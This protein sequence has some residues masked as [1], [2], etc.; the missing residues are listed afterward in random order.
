MSSNY[1]NLLRGELSFKE[2]R[3]RENDDGKNN[4]ESL[5]LGFLRDAV[6]SDSSKNLKRR[7]SIAGRG[8][9][10]FNRRSKKIPQLLTTK[11]LLERRRRQNQQR[12][13]TTPYSTK[14]SKIRGL[15]FSEASPNA[16]PHKHAK[17][18]T[19]PPMVYIK[20]RR[21]PKTSGEPSLLS[22]VQTSSLKRDPGLTIDTSSSTL[23]GSSF[24]H[25]NANSRRP[26]TSPMV[27]ISKSDAAMDEILNDFNRLPWGRRNIAVGKPIKRR[28]YR[29]STHR[30]SPQ[31][32]QFPA[33]DQLKERNVLPDRRER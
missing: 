26:S 22:M 11:D 1:A 33:I 14:R 10:N 21:R 15:R 30:I 25:N 3:M 17:L 12:P 27:G 29:D 24:L 31:H 13:S 18:D 16:A 19:S 20:S 9:K 32:L 8:S 2:L 7:R 23:G 6:N 5:L 4:D 28:G